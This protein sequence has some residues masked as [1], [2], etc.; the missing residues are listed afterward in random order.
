MRFQGRQRPIRPGV[1]HGKE[2]GF[3]SKCDRKDF[4]WFKIEESHDLM[5]FQNVTGH[6]VEKGLGA[7]ADGSK[8][9][10]GRKYGA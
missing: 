1:C 2:I 3:P 4:G 6:R 8:T 5:W 7:T 9:W 10:Q